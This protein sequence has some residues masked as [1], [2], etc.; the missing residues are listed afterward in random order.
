MRS[1]R[2]VDKLVRA[3][4]DLPDAGVRITAY[5][6]SALILFELG[7]HFK[8]RADIITFDNESK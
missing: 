4:P 3:Q 5:S 7:C 2:T 6:Y 1:K 8:V